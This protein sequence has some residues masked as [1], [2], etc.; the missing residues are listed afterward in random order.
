MSQRPTKRRESRTDFHASQNF[1]DLDPI[2]RY[3]PVP[4]I[5]RRFRHRQSQRSSCA[6]HYISQKPE[7][8]LLLCG[9]KPAYR[10]SQPP[11]CEV[12]TN[13]DICRF[14]D[15]AYGE[16]QVAALKADLNCFIATQH[17][18]KSCLG[19]VTQANDSEEV[20]ITA[21][22]RSRR[23]GLLANGLHPTACKDGSL[24]PPRNRLVARRQ[25][26]GTSSSMC[27]RC[28]PTAQQRAVG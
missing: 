20:P 21:L 22:K 12:R 10:P 17:L 26:T 4:E 24:R 9:R 18:N 25:R 15:E 11:Q 28:Q 8:R 3:E 1:E 14:R 7:E 5:V 13:T 23:G 27:P 19:V 2:D 6:L 16:E